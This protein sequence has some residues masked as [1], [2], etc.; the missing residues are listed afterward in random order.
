MTR[1]CG[2]A[3]VHIYRAFDVRRLF[4]VALAKAH[5][6]GSPLLL[7]LTESAG[8]D[9]FAHL[10]ALATGGKAPDELVP[11]NLG[12]EA[13]EGFRLAPTEEPGSLSLTSEMRPDARVV[14]VA[15]LQLIAQRRIEVLALATG[16]QDALRRIEDGT[17]SAADLVETILGAGSLAVLPWG[18]G[19]WIGARGREVAELAASPRFDDD[20]LFFLGDCAQ[21]AWLWPRPRVFRSRRVLPGSDILPVADAEA[22]IAG[23]GFQ[24]EA[25]YDAARPA[26]SLI[27]GLRRGEPVGVLGRRESFGSI[28]REQLAFRRS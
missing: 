21:R 7:M 19:K 1:I 20:A 23:Y 12:P 14:I 5:E 10:S 13:L 18:L 26:A 2:D 15:G 8:D 28:L 27:A 22:R 3:H 6:L 4:T 16:P 17:T 24:L 11:E 9:Y 25:E